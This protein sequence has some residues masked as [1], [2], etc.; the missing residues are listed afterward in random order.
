MT[1]PRERVREI[2]QDLAALVA[3][4]FRCLDGHDGDGAALLFAEDVLWITQRHGTIAGRAAA[5]RNIAGRP[6]GSV[7]RHCIANLAVEV[8]DE[9][10]AASTATVVIWA[11]DGGDAPA[12]LPLAIGLPAAILDF[13][14]R[15]SRDDHG[16]RIASLRSDAVF[17]R[18]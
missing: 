11:V 18:P 7:S 4:F 6:K 13:H 12:A 2:E 8:M 14:H 15:F 17:A 5:A 3:R 16:W 10:N 1:L 9:S